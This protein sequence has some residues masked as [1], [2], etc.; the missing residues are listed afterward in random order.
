LARPRLHSEDAILDAARALVLDGGARAATLNAIAAASG[1]P[2]GS[3]YHRFES[4]D[5]LL[6]ALWIRAVRRSQAEFIQA[7]RAPGAMPAAIGAALS[8]YDFAARAPADARL[9]A[10]LRRE[11]LVHAT[12]QRERELAA[13]NRPLER[14]L[15]ALTRRLFGMSTPANVEATV[16]AIVDLPIG[17]VRRHLIAGQPLPSRARGQLEAAVRASL[18]HAGARPN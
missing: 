12:P 5:E 15:A 10:S 9:L 3:I 1:A 7:M 13:L 17:A 2:K 8:I 6:A 14:A 4:L 11:D 16:T 18:L